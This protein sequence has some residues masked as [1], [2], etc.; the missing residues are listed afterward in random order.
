VPKTSSGRWR[1]AA[2]RLS[3]R[4]AQRLARVYR[5]ECGQFIIR[6]A[7]VEA[8]ESDDATLWVDAATGDDDY[9][10]AEI[11]A[12]AGTLAW[13]TIGRA[14]W[15]S[16]DWNNPVAAE[17][18]TAGD[19][20]AIIGGPDEGSATL[21]STDIIIKD[22][23]LPVYLP[24]NP[25]TIGNYLT[26]RAY[27]YVRF[28]AHLANA[29]VVGFRDYVK[30][31]A[32]RADSR[33]LITC[34][35]RLGPV[36]TITSAVLSGGN[37]LTITTEEEHNIH[38]SGDQVRIN[39]LDTTPPLNSTSTSDLIFIATVTG[40][41]TFTINADLYFDV[42][43]G[44]TTG[45]CQVMDDVTQTDTTKVNPKPDHGP[46][47]MTGTAPWLEGFDI[48]GGVQVDYSDNWDGVRTA[49]CI[50]G[51]I[52]NNRIH[53]FRNASGSGN[54]AA[55]K[56]YDS[57]GMLIERN[58]L[59]DSGVGIAEKTAPTGAAVDVQDNVFRRNRISDC[60]YGVVY[61]ISD[62]PGGDRVSQ[63]ILERITE[64]AL[65]ITGGD[66]HNL[67]FFNNTIVGMQN[68]V[69][70][71]ALGHSG[72]RIWGNIFYGTSPRAIEIDGATWPTPASVLNLQ[73]NVYVFEGGTFYAGSDGL[74]D[75][76]SF[77]SAYPGH[78]TNTPIAV[79]A[80]E[81]P[82]VFVDVASENYRLAASSPA[83]NITVD[84]GDLD[85]D[86]STTDTVHAGYDPTDVGV[87]V[88]VES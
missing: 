85:G 28:G 60:R 50:D 86:G 25:G 9:T 7:A 51:V 82:L 21:Y 30:W 46:V 65:W 75:F 8:V 64:I 83:R 47:L 52:R 31:Y 5:D 74:R 41:N 13:A 4:V 57:R 40:P 72:C 1:R 77:N 76:A 11:R 73:H 80:T 66:V 88:G 6:P 36:L 48:D 49:E 37:L 63:N 22:R 39:A 35:G 69:Y 14:V 62:D 70:I 42:T 23:N 16:Q 56:V 19:V 29:P 10:I 87:A 79:V 18:A 44:G 32:N 78:H 33:F 3:R 54:G 55:V 20:V 15:G 59:Y 81:P 58:D 27:G 38:E 17:A 26:F 24:A 68:G 84:I 43:A 45:T 53:S 12:G 34:D 67:W 71:S 61:S 2:R